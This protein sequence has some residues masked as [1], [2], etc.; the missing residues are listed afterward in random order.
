MVNNKKI[1]NT[2]NNLEIS[3]FPKVLPDFRSKL[4]TKD[5]LIASW[6]KIWIKNGMNSNKLKEGQLLP[7]KSDISRYL[8]VSLGTVQSAIRLVEDEGLLQSKQRIG[9]MIATGSVIKKQESNRDIAIGAIKNLIIKEYK[10]GDF[11]GATKE[12]ADKIKKSL[13]ITKQALE[14]LC[15]IGIL[16]DFEYRSSK[17]SWKIKE[18]PQDFLAEHVSSKTLVEKVKEELE[19]Y[20]NNNLQV[21]E[22][23]PSSQDMARIFGVSVKTIHD[24]MQPLI[25]NGCLVARRGQ[26]GT[27]IAKMPDDMSETLENRIFAPAMSVQLYFYEKIRERLQN[28]I[29][30]NYNINDKLPSI[31]ELSKIFD[32]SSNTI[33]KAL[34]NWEEKEIIE[35]RRGRYGGT[36]FVK[37]PDDIVNV[38]KLAG[39]NSSNIAFEWLALKAQKVAK[40]PETIDVSNY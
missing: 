24:A 36:F 30:K 35:Y 4:Q 6:L 12:I 11:L 33:R 28:F 7:L 5:V 39:E 32:V 27:I 15:Y 18:M 29:L 37:M 25:K 10:K 1:K 3:D 26:Y 2:Q 38:E 20:I 22:K 40:S 13:N 21:N 19:N 9:T 17:A 31:E 14:H 34:E 16:D 23:L 8:G